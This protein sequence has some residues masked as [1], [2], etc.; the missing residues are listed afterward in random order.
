MTTF[1]TRQRKNL[2]KKKMAMPDGSYPIRNRSDLRNAISSYGRAKNKRAVKTWIIRRAKE[3][4]STDLIP[5]SWMTDIKQAAEK[6]E[7]AENLKLSDDSEYLIHFGVKGMKWGIRKQK[8]KSSS[9]ISKKKP[10]RK[11]INTNEHD[12]LLY[13]KRGAKRIQRNIETK[14]MSRKKARN[15]E[16]LRALGTA[17]LYSAASAGLGLALSEAYFNKS[18]LSK[19]AF[20]AG[21]KVASSFGNYSYKNAAKYVAGNIRN[22]KNGVKYLNLTNKKIAIL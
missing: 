9:Q 22:A 21:Q 20:K 5:D 11:Y 15:R 6:L 16:Q 14:G 7:M 12:N 4:D 13:G 8:D 19:S 18:K 1:T 10:L 17:A 2:T 3:L